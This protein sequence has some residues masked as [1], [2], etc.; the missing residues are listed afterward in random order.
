MV[1]FCILLTEFQSNQDSNCLGIWSTFTT[2]F[3]IF[4]LHLWIIWT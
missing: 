3:P 1:A 2:I 4:I